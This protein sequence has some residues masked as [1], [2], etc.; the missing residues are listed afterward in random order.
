MVQTVALLEHY[1]IDGE[2]WMINSV[3]ALLK[4]REVTKD[5]TLESNV[6]IEDES[7]F[8][9]TFPGSVELIICRVIPT[10]TS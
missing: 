7:G 1:V 5:G 4:T 10:R 6:K 8:H 9:C 2:L 3:R